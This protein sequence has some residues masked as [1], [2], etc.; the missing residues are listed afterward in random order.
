MEAHTDYRA[1][2]MTLKEVMKAKG[3]TY[4]LLASK[5]GTSEVTIKRIFSQGQSCTLDRLFEI[6]EALGVSFF[7]IVALAKR[8][9]EVDYVLTLE[10]ENHFAAKPA[11]FAILKE[12]IR[13]VTAEQ[14]KKFWELKDSD[15]FKILRSLEK[16]G[17]I[18]LL[19]ENKVRI[20]IRGNIRMAHRG[21]LAKKILRPQI[22]EFLNHIDR[23]LENKDVC[24]HSAET[25]LS[26]AHIKEFVA[27]IHALGAKYRARAFRDRNLLS[28]KKLKSV[29]WLFGFA[30]F[31]TDWRQW[32]D[33]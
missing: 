31:Q 9:E 13:G 21:P 6:C 33:R 26:E 11:H 20:K 30:P 18:D 16:L 14:I 29:R 27:E 17:L 28:A 7:D 25:E 19:P 5:I 15:Y 23:T 4:G 8:E 12:L 24:M 3:F 10:Q 22:N 32:Q 2:F 1:L